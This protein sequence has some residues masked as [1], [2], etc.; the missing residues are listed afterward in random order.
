M[1]VRKEGDVIVTPKQRG[2]FTDFNDSGRVSF[3]RAIGPLISAPRSLSHLHCPTRRA[4]E[5]GGLLVYGQNPSSNAPLSAL[6]GPVHWRNTLPQT[7]QKNGGLA[8]AP[9]AGGVAQ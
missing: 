4:R 1:G 9:G 6:P 2:Q 5:P 7:Q 8:L 3:D